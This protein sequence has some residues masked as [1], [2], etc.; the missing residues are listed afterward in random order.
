MPRRLQHL[1]ATL[2][3]L[4]V[5]I[6]HSLEEAEAKVSEVNALIAE[7]AGTGLLMHAVLL[8][9]ISRAALRPDA[10]TSTPSA[11]FKRPFCPLKVWHMSMDSRDA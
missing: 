5:Q 4:N 1:A 2:T 7:L 9:K 6:K 3:K 11:S 8:G 10:G